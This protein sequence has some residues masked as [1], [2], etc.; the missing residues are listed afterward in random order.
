MQLLEAATSVMRAAVQRLAE[1]KATQFSTLSQNDLQVGF[2]LLS[3]G[4]FIITSIILYVLLFYFL[5]R[6][7]CRV[8]VN[9]KMQ[10]L[11]Q[12]LFE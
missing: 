12:T 7:F 1:V 6:C 11:E 3:N 9:A 5:F 4:N 10:M 2:L 8:K